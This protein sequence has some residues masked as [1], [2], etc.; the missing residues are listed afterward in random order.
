MNLS[1]ICNIVFFLGLL[2]LSLMKMNIVVISSPLSQSAHQM[3]S[4]KT[5]SFDSLMSARNST[6]FEEA[7]SQSSN[8]SSTN[9][10]EDQKKVE[11]EERDWNEA[12][13]AKYENLS[14]NCTEHIPPKWR[15]WMRNHPPPKAFDVCT[16]E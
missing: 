13:F 16:Y 2:L 6:T 1:V 12:V 9:M 7:L 11:E 14:L 10:L 4:N 3:L 15:E 5:S 8:S